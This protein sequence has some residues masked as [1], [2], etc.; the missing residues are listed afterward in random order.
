MDFSRRELAALLPAMTAAIAAAQQQGGEKKA[1]SGPPAV[2]PSK[3]YEFNDLPEH[4]NGAKTSKGRAFFSGITTRGQQLSLHISE[5]APG[6]APHLPHQH[7][8]EEIIMLC[9]GTLEVEIHAKVGEF[10]HGEKSRVGPGSVIYFA[11]NDPHGTRNVGQT[12]AKYFVI[13]VGNHT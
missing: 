5:L 7:I 2:L 13:A 4:V 1:D 8:N 3:A 9:E 12:W 6:Q 11:S 10:G